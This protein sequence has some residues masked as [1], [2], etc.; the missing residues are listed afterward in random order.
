MKLQILS[1]ATLISSANAFSPS[2]VPQP[3]STTQTQLNLF[4]GKKE[5]GEGGG[6]MMDQLAM[7]KKAQEIA[8][9]KMEIDKELAKMEHVGSAADGKVT[10]SVKYIAPAPMQ[11]PGYEPTSV[12][13]D[14]EWMTG[15]SV[16]ELN[17]ALS[18]AMLSGLRAATEATAEKMQILTNELGEVMQSMQGGGAA[19]A[20][21]AEG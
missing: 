17:S 16:E 18:E 19:P 5:K 1:I 8:S 2:F 14:D 9:K 10:I 6:G 7:L 12:K 20:A 4:G 15:V 13:I 3:V 21:P 11:Q